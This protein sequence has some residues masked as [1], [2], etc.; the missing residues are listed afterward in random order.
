MKQVSVGSRQSAKRRDLLVINP[1]VRCGCFTELVEHH[2]L[3]ASIKLHVYSFIVRHMRV[4]RGVGVNHLP[5]VLHH[6]RI[7]SV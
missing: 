6:S 2:S 4:G 3:W 5:G 1:V 7:V